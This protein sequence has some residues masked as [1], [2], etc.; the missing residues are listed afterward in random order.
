MEI[1]R[2]PSM[3][4]QLAADTGHR[5][6]SWARPETQREVLALRLASPKRGEA[7]RP[8]NMQFGTN[9]LPLFGAGQGGLF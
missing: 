9:D 1:E 5:I 6:H 2:A 8:T 3:L 4:E 7:G